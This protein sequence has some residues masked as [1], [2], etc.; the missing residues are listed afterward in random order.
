MCSNVSSDV[1][2]SFGDDLRNIADELEAP[3][4]PGDTT[5]WTR[6]HFVR[7]ESAERNVP[8]ST[9]IAIARFSVQMEPLAVPFERKT[10]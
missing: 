10:L 4:R 7:L 3:P 5:Y 8:C 9:G 1:L 6:A 2:R